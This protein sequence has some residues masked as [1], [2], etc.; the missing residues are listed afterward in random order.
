MALS[1][2]QLG[3]IHVAERELGLDDDQYRDILDAVAGVRSAKDLDNL[4]FELV[5]GRFVALGFTPSPKLQ[6]PS[7]GYRPEMATPEQLD[8]IR[9]LW[10]RWSDGRGG[11]AGFRGWLQHTCKVSDARFLTDEQAR[12]AIT[13]LM[14]MTRRAKARKPVMTKRAEKARS[15]PRARAS[16]G[17]AE[18]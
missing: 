6:K 4:D 11:E 3:M 8:L 15:A 16:Q 17:G 18:R 9:G 14:A 12:K 1:R 7:Y 10:G 13:G 2:R 5:M